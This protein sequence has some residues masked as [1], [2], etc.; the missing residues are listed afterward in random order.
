M[1]FILEG[2]PGKVKL[3]YSLALRTRVQRSFPRLWN[4]FYARGGN[5]WS[6]SSS[7]GWLLTGTPDR[8]HPLSHSSVGKLGL[9][10]SHAP[11]SIMICGQ[12]RRCAV[13]LL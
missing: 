11:S 9:L 13:S 1:H 4:Q 6:A 8:L 10:G 7:P 2:Q 5:T 12:Q 3:D